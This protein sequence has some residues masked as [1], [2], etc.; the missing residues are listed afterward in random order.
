MITFKNN[1]LIDTIIREI[2][3]PMEKR[4]KSKNKL[5]IDDVLEKLNT[6]DIKTGREQESDVNPKEIP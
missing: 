2:Q 3:D 6:I 1:K 5:P 4:V